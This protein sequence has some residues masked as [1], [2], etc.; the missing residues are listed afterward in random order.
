[1]MRQLNYVKSYDNYVNYE[2]DLNNHFKLFK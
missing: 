1:M 2:H